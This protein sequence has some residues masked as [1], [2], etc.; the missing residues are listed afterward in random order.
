MTPRCGVIPLARP[1]V[2]PFL[3]SAPAA[4]SPT[5]GFLPRTPAPGR[6]G[7]S[8]HLTPCF[9][10]DGPRGQQVSE[11]QVVGQTQQ[12]HLVPEMGPHPFLPP[13]LHG[14][15]IGS[16]AAGDLRPRQVRLLLEPH[17][18]LRE[19]VGEDVG[20]SAV[21]DALSRHGASAFQGTSARPFPHGSIQPRREPRAGRRGRKSWVFGL[22][23]LPSSG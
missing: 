13:P 16:K 2:R 14:V 22:S 4:A 19:V 3:R 18:A 23:L 12:G 20:S 15:G 17:Q 7:W 10:P 21:V 8:G 5:C 1:C 9:V 6:D 11:P